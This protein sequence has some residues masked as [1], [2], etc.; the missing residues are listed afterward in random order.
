MC[1]KNFQLE[2]NL[3]VLQ[4]FNVFTTQIGPKM[5]KMSLSMHQKR[6][7]IPLDIPSR[8]P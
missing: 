3:L 1:K 7:R 2:V 5:Y 4:N 8:L 6:A